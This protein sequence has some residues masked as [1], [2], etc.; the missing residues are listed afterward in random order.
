MFTSPR[1]STQGVANQL[2]VDL[3]LALWGLLDEKQQQGVKLDYLQVFELSIEYVFGEVFQKVTHSQ[4]V[5]PF[6][7]TYYY[8]EISQPI[9]GKVFVI[10]SEDYVTMMLATEY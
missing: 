3:Q 10:D 9:R 7:E 4:E 8:R 2:S 6:S 5:L 1:Y